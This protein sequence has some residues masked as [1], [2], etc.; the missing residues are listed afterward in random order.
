VTVHRLPSHFTLR[1]LR[2]LLLLQKGKLG[3]RGCN[4][5]SVAHRR[6]KVW[7]KYKWMS[8]CASSK[9]GPVSLCILIFPHGTE[10]TCLIKKVLIRM[11]KKINSGSRRNKSF[12]CLF[13]TGVWTR[14]RTCKGWARLTVHFALVIFGDGS[15]SY[16]LP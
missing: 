12:V 1:T 8:K 4:D 7:K 5:S 13:G 15:V 6:W 3:Y 2:H 11:G 10:I 16:Y 14:L 9:A